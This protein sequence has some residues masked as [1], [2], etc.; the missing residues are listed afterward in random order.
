MIRRR[1][2][3]DGVGNAEDRSVCPNSKRENG[4]DGNQE[5]GMLKQP[6]QRVQE[7]LGHNDLIISESFSTVAQFLAVQMVESFESK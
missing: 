1:P 7:I 3:E 4:N 2:Q 6:S 5:P